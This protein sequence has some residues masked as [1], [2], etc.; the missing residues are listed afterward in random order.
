M[1]FEVKMILE[2]A[3]VKCLLYILAS[4]TSLDLFSPPFEM[5][6]V[7]QQKSN[8]RSSD[9]ATLSILTI[10]MVMW[11]I[12]VRKSWADYAVCLTMYPYSCLSCD[13]YIYIDGNVVFLNYAH[14]S[15]V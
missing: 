12:G 5:V 2:V 7:L 6:V 9:V 14:L 3:T 10:V 8:P 15:E 11:S 13:A 4:R 1:S